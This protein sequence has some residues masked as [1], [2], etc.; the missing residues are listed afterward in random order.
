MTFLISQCLFLILLYK[1]STENIDHSNVTEENF[2]YQNDIDHLKE[3]KGVRWSI[4]DDSSSLSNHVINNHGNKN[5]TASRKAGILVW[6]L[7]E[8]Y[9]TGEEEIAFMNKSMYHKNIKV[10]RDTGEC[11]HALDMLRKHVKKY[12]IV[13]EIDISM[14][15]ER[16]A[17]ALAA[18]LDKNDPEKIY[19]SKAEDY[20]GTY[21]Q[22]IYYA[23]G[24]KQ[25]PG[26]GM[27]LTAW[28]T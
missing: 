14:K 2:V 3:V 12:M 15:A 13:H 27:A 24:L 11:Q 4:G 9:W 19:M 21:G 28:M 8:K 10:W 7:D 5:D 20:G 23:D 17:I 1:I 18:Y 6:D 22:L 25:A 26:C 16:W